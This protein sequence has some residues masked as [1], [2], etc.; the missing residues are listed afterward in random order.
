MNEHYIHLKDETIEAFIA[1]VN[2]R[3]I[4]YSSDRDLYLKSDMD[5]KLLA[6]KNALNEF[7]SFNPKANM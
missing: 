1:Y 4:F 7:E 5:S 6:W 3:I 2:S